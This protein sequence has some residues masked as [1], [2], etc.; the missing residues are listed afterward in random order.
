VIALLH[1]RRARARGHYRTLDRLVVAVVNLRPLA[2]DGRPVA[3]V[4]ISNALGQRGERERIR[5]EIGLAFAIADGEWGAHASADQQ[6]GKIAEQDGDRESAMKAG[7]NGGDRFFG[8]PALRQFN[9]DEV[10]DDLRIRLAFEVAAERAH[11]LAQGAEILDDAVMDERHS[12]DDVR[13]R[14]AHRG[15]PV[16]RPARVGDPDRPGERVGGELAGEVFE[17]ALR[18]AAFEPAIDDRADARAIVAAIFE[19][20]QPVEQSSRYLLPADNADDS[21]HGYAAFRIV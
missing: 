14:I 10:G 5:A 8:V 16:G 11:L 13:M 6:L 3:L 1:R 21:A 2:S 17:L 15:S 9:R 20:L 18:S 19:P 7:Q 4:Q 12:I